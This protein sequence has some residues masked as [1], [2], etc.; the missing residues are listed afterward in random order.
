VDPAE[1]RKGKVKNDV[2]DK[3]RME[4]N[5]REKKLN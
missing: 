3:M 1:E 4:Q 5:G 2:T